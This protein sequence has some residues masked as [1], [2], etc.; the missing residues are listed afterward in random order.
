L[1]TNSDKAI[2][3]DSD[4]NIGH[5][6]DSATE[7]CEKITS[8]NQIDVLLRAQCTWNS[9]SVYSFTGGPYGLRIQEVPYVNK[10]STPI[11][12]F[13]LFFMQLIICWQRLINAPV[14]I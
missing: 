14:N 7:G 2:S 4:S 13:L 5:D 9:G 10:D 12:F 1:E 8:G 6:G 3:S 11:I